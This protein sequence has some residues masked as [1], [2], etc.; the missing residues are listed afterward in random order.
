MQNCH[1]VTT[2]LRSKEYL[3]LWAK[4]TV[5]AVPVRYELAVPAGR[6]AGA[7][8]RARRPVRR[9]RHWAVTPVRSDRVARRGRGALSPP[10]VRRP[11]GITVAGPVTAAAADRAGRPYGPIRRITG[12]CELLPPGVDRATVSARLVE[13]PSNPLTTHEVDTLTVITPTHSGECL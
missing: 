5:Q 8:P 6:G 1:G 11:G 13:I 4:D 12:D 10:T 9:R 3:T 2:M 7:A